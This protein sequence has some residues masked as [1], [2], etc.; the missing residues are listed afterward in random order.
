[1]Q[2]LLVRALVCAFWK[3]PFTG[4]LL[5]WG[6]A[7]HDRFMLP[8][9]VQRDFAEVLGF[10]QRAG[11]PLEDKW[12]ATH[13]EFRFPKIGSISADGVELELRQ[14]LEPWN[15]LAEETNSGRTGRSVDSSL[16]RMQ[17]KV[18]GLTTESRYIVTCN[19]RRVPLHP[20]GEPGEAVAGIRYR[21][22]RLSAALHPTIPVHTPL[23]FD[24]IDTWKQ[25][26]I[27]R[28]TYFSGPPDGTNHTTRSRQRYRSEGPPLAALPGLRTPSANPSSHPRAE[29][30]NPI[31]PMTLDLA[32]ARRPP[33]RSIPSTIEHAEDRSMIGDLY[34][35]PLTLRR[36]Y[37]ESSIDGITPRP[38]L[39]S[40]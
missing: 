20:T 13:V 40:T 34:Q 24:L 23:T 5:R 14:A 6:T 8:H 28:C 36:T 11:Y 37:E 22:R 18:T 31:F 7:L 10:L 25:R 3:Q 15:V 12:F 19:G 4:S 21:A 1:M 2:M 39:G 33:K 17:V 27:G 30:N 9:F 32:L 26:S 38:A 35:S 29:E 16:E